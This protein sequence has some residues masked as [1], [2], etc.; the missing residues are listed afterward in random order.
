MEVGEAE[1]FKNDGT[2]QVGEDDEDA[3]NVS[4]D[5]AVLAN[6]ATAIGDQQAK[7]DAL[8]PEEQ[9][10]LRTLRERRERLR[11]ATR[12]RRR[13]ARLRHD[14]EPEAVG[15]KRRAPRGGR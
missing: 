1:L 11:Q 13:E 6:V 9:Q 7:F 2:P 8:P 10:R 15:Q 5:D 14:A 4:D 3:A 12:E